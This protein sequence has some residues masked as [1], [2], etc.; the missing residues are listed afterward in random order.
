MFKGITALY[1][2][3]EKTIRDSIGGL[4]RTFFKSFIICEN[5]VEN[6][7]NKEHIYILF[8]YHLLSYQMSLIYKYI[9]YSGTEE[10][11]YS[12]HSWTKT[13]CKGKSN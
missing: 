11:F 6:I 3:D 5:E 12:C 8:V 4:L 2:E 9:Y 10:I 1:V 13:R 7:K